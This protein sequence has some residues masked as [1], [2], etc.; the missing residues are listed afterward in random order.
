MP[1]TFTADGATWTVWPTGRNTQYVRDEFGLLFT[2]GAGA[3]RERRVARYSPGGAR[4]R[5]LSLGELTDQ[6][7]RGLL[8]VSQ[9]AWTAPETGYRR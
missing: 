5:E 3:E 1:R 7:L 8:A 4:I 2:R 9:P 6:D